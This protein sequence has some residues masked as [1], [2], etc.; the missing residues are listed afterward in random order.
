[1][2]VTKLIDEASLG[3]FFNVVVLLAVVVYICHQYDIIFDVLTFILFALHYF[4]RDFHSFSWA[5]FY[6]F[7]I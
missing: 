1:M 3:I 5:H 2:A 7:L 4:F 6:S